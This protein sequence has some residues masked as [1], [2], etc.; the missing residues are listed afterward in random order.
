MQLQMPLN[1][2]V[3][4]KSPLTEK[5]S[6]HSGCAKLN[7]SALP[8]EI[9]EGSGGMKIKRNLGRLDQVLRAGIGFILIYIG[10]VDDTLVTDRLIAG[11]LGVFGLVNIAVSLIG[12]CPVYLLANINTLPS[13]D[14]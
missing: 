10:F 2:R 9:K 14:A 4:I 1:C 12:M 7:G 8:S 6:D 3:F 11:A 13:N 5:S